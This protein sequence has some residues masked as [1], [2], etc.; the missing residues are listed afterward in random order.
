MI[1]FYYLQLIRK[2]F[3]IVFYKI[4]HNFEFKFSFLMG[5]FLSRLKL[6][7]TLFF[8]KKNKW[9]SRNIQPTVHNLH[10][11]N[12]VILQANIFQRERERDRRPRTDAT[13]LC[14]TFSYIFRP[15]REW[16]YCC[17]QR[18]GKKNCFFVRCYNQ[19]Y[20]SFFMI[21]Q[22][23]S[24]FLPTLK[25]VCIGSIYCSRWNPK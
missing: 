18:K 10:N 4:I 1:F 14:D 13:R 20:I 25:Q 3:Q 2:L 16:N 8:E 19:Y 15:R 23:I 21:A 7:L 6:H 5:S 9:I 11:S 22:K 24:R 17:C 12:I